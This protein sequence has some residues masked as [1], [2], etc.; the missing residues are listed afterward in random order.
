MKKEKKIEI[1]IKALQKNKRK[2]FRVRANIVRNIHK[3]K[4]QIELFRERISKRKI[5][6][7]KKENQTKSARKKSLRKKDETVFKGRKHTIS[8]VNLHQQ[9]ARMILAGRKKN[10]QKKVV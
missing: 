10:L 5:K 7:R 1:I 8:F 4:P 6:K 9:I 2:E 3:V